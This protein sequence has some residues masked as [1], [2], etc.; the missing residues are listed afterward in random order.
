MGGP[1]VCVEVA[2]RGD[3]LPID[4][5][6]FQRESISPA[7]YLASSYYQLWLRGLEARLLAKGLVTATELSS[8]RSMSQ[9]A[10]MDA[11]LRGADVAAASVT[12]HRHTRPTEVDAAYAAGD[13][14]R[15]RNIHPTGHTRLPRYARGHVGTIERIHGCMVFPDSN[16]HGQGEDPQWCYTVSFA[17][18]ELWGPDADSRGSVSL[19]LWEPYLDPA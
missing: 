4:A 5:K 1:H 11:I 12:P 14:V 7:E 13:R 17:S 10:N 19:D 2:F 8:G 16:A 3:K 18:R 9:P 15:T 6:R